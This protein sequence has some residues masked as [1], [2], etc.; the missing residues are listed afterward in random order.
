MDVRVRSLFSPRNC[1]RGN[2]SSETLTVF[3]AR[4]RS[5]SQTHTFGELFKSRIGAQ[6]V[7][8]RVAVHMYDHRAPVLD[9]AF[10]YVECLV[11][12]TQLSEGTGSFE[13]RLGIAVI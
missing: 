12:L 7:Q 4:S 3:L 8:P 10:K 9:H 11:H 2:S 5:L 1:I 6:G 13:V